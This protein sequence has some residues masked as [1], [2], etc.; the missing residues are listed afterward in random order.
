M[1][2]GVFR[3]SISLAVIILEG[4]GNIQFLL[5]IILAIATAKITAD[6]FIEGLNE[7]SLELMTLTP[8]LRQEPSHAMLSMSAGAVAATPVVKFRLVESVRTIVSALESCGHNAFPVCL[9]KDEQVDQWQYEGLILR[10]QLMVLL[11]KRA[12]RPEGNFAA[13]GEPA[14]MV[15]SQGILAIDRAMREY[16]S[17]FRST[18]S[19]LAGKQKLGA[20][21]LSAHEQD[22][23]VDLTPY[24]NIAPIAVRASCPLQRAFK[25]FRSMGIRHLVVVDGN[26]CVKGIITRKDLSDHHD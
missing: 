21:G 23:C 9:V 1:L 15:V 12:M 7:E 13:D 19:S 8:F 6:R 10:S 17:R 22:Q 20:L 25:H 2:S 14:A 11:D 5:P 18:R 24:M 26:N 16:H 4:T 3:S